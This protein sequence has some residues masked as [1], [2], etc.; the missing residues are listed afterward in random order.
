M[1][2]ALA[3]FSIVILLH[4][5]SP[6]IAH[7]RMS[8]VL[9]MVIIIWSVGSFFAA[10]FQCDTPNVWNTIDG[11]CYNRVSKVAEVILLY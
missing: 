10:A 2:I 4:N 8:Q 6:D 1:T 7:Q 5:I 3:K 11:V 9:G